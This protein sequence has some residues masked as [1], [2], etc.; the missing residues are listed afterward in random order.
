MLENL[1]LRR[2]DIKIEP[3]KEILESVDKLIKSFEED[4]LNISLV[5]FRFHTYSDVFGKK[6]REPLSFLTITAFPILDQ[7]GSPQG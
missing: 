3:P 4:G 6:D 7:E 5:D 1:K 2:V